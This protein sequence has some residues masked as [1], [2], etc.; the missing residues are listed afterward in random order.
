MEHEALLILPLKY[1]SKVS[2]DTQSPSQVS[3]VLLFRDMCHCSVFIYFGN[4]TDR[5]GNLT[6]SYQYHELNGTLC[7]GALLSSSQEVSK[8][9][10]IQCHLTKL[11]CLREFTEND[12]PHEAVWKD[13]H[14]CLMPQF[15][16]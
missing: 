4:S 11:W 16:F 7:Q 5:L 1:A 9:S 3:S 12:S 6:S 14:E 10:Q 2:A 8:L 13:H 15:L